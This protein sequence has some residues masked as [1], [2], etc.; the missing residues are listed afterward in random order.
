MRLATK[1]WHIKWRKVATLSVRD[2]DFFCISIVEFLAE[3]NRNEDG[4]L[5]ELGLGAA[6]A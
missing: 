5:D 3:D 2:S 1:Q 6:S 4:E